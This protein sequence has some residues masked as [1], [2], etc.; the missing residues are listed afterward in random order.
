MRTKKEAL[1]A[2]IKS[3]A[4]LHCWYAV[5]TDDLLDELV[6]ISYG[7]GDTVKAGVGHL[8]DATSTESDHE[9][10]YPGGGNHV[11]Q[12]MHDLDLL[13]YVRKTPAMALKPAEQIIAMIWA[14]NAEL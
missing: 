1:Y 8:L 10:N 3:F 14:N 6:E 13:R 4:A 12:Y 11:W 5:I 7:T 9:L 2:G